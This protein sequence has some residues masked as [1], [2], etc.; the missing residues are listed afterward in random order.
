MSPAA[1]VPDQAQTS[2]A[3]ERERRHM[4]ARAFSSGRPG[5]AGRTDVGEV[6]GEGEGEGGR[7]ARGQQQRRRQRDAE[8][9]RQQRAPP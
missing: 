5:R 4:A 7:A 6:E 1:A 3:R 8:R 9:E 2:A